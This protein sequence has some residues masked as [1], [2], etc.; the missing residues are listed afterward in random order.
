[1]CRRRWEDNIKLDLQGVGWGGVDWI[2][3]AAVAGTC[4]CGDEPSGFIKCGNFLTN[5]SLCVVFR[6]Q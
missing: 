6:I 1:M 5:W 2:D 4:E 3:L